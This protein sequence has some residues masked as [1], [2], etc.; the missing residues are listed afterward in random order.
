M[1]NSAAKLRSRSLRAPWL[2]IKESYLPL[3][4]ERVRIND[5]IPLYGLIIGMGLIFLAVLLLKWIV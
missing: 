2:G 4:I 3:E 5:Y 1:T